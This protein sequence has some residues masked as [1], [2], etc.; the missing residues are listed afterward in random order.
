MIDC[1]SD[2]GHAFA[3]FRDS[4]GLLA[5]ARAYFNDTQDPFALTV[6]GRTFYVITQ[7]KHSAEVYKNTEALSFEDFVQTLMKSNGNSDDV[8]KT[9]YSALS[10]DKTGFPNPQGESLGVLAQKMHIYQLHPG[11]NLI[12]IQQRVQEWIDGKLA[13]DALGSS[14]PYGSRVGSSIE[15]PL[16]QWCS[17]YFVKL[18]QN[19]YFGD[20]LHS[21]DPELPATFLEFDEQIWKMLY[22]YPYYLSRD[23][24]K[25]RSRVIESLKKYF[26]VPQ[27]QRR[28]QAAW[29]INAMED[30][31]T[32]LGID[33]NNLAVL[34]FHLYFAINTNTRKTVFWLLTYL[35]HNPALL[36][37]YTEETKP[38]FDGSS[39]VD[40]LYIQDATKCP[41][42]SAIWHETLRLSGWSASV[43]LIKQD[44]VIGGK[45]MRKGN[46]VLV[47]H[48]LLHF[49]T[50]TFGADTHEFH[51]ERWLKR[52]DLWHSPSWRPFGGGKTMCSGRFLARFSVTTFVA[53][54]LQRFDI[55][56]VGDPP[57]PRADEGRPVLGIMS[58]KDGEDFK[59]RL[60]RKRTC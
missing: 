5:E 28:D 26:E 47:P 16:Y 18:G 24:S 12:V 25:A 13:I 22:S 46:R 30:E 10:A 27:S 43:R 56:I 59:V 55:E 20:I 60:S 54:L 45:L 29:L 21:I 37:A 11:N 7:A 52:T 2:I 53:T 36:K 33:D 1:A 14:C 6:L 49:D 58:I 42:V 51:P 9:M 39:L 3:F 15:L 57:F 8:I 48:R 31:I 19:I 38:A 17:D 23:M 35:L 40:P 32:A 44:T 41:Q 34:V 50:R 4:N